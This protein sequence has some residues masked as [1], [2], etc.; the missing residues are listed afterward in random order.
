[1]M[2]LC[3][4]FSNLEWDSRY[5]KDKLLIFK[6]GLEGISL[7]DFSLIFFVVVNVQSTLK[8]FKMIDTG[9]LYH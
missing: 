9:R 6:L 4:W 7:F 3:T 5:E 1:M 2:W 8:S